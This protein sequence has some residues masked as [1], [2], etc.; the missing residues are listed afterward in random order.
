MVLLNLTIIVERMTAMCGSRSTM[1]CLHDMEAVSTTCLK[2]MAW[3]DSTWQALGWAAISGLTWLLGIEKRLQS[4]YGSTWKLTTHTV[5]I[6]EFT[7][8]GIQIIYKSAG[9]VPDS[10]V[11]I[12]LYIARGHKNVFF[13]VHGSFNLIKDMMNPIH[14]NSSHWVSTDRLCRDRPVIPPGS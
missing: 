9:S 14:H 13:N 5:L 6:L 3:G 8:L 11:C 2:N 4:L 7:S 1:L 10:R 12:I